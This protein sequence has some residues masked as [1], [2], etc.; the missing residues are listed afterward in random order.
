MSAFRCNSAASKLVQNKQIHVILKVLTACDRKWQK[1]WSCEKKENVHQAT[2]TMQPDLGSSYGALRAAKPYEHNSYLV[3]IFGVVYGNVRPPHTVLAEVLQQIVFLSVS[4]WMITILD[5][6]VFKRIFFRNN[7]RIV[8]GKMWVYKRGRKEHYCG[9]YCYC[10]NI[11]SGRWY[12]VQ[13]SYK[14][15]LAKISMW[16]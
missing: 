8:L 12:E 11:L 15:F 9:K 13:K 2:A 6:A 5:Y 16:F 7:K 10:S 1:T 3:S 14:T 4:L